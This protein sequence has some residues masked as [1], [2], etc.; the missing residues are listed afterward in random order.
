MFISIKKLNELFGF[1][2]VEGIRKNNKLF[3]EEIDKAK[4]KSS[5]KRANQDKYKNIKIE[6]L[7]FVH[8]LGEGQFGKVYLVEDKA[9]KYRYALKCMSKKEI[10]ANEM[11]TYVKNEKRIL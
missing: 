11:E 5:T 2:I 10:M 1:D 8:S 9:T 3:H 4:L 7:Y 6:N